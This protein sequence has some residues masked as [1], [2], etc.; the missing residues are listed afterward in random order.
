MVTGVTWILAPY[1]RVDNAAK[2]IEFY[3]NALGATEIGRYPTDGGKI[4]HAEL[5]LHGNKLCLADSDSPGSAR[6]PGD[7]RRVPVSLY[8]I[9][10][11]VDDV[12]ARAIAAGAT[13]DYAPADQSYGERGAGFVDPFGHVW[14]IGQPIP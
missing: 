4:A 11:D 9:V 3:V 7:A 14:F 13:S 5:D 2:A 10:P 6:N 8:A 1:L 12:Y